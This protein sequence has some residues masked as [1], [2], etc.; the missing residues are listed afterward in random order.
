[1][2][3]ATEA[4]KEAAAAAAKAACRRLNDARVLGRAYDPS[5]VLALRTNCQARSQSQPTH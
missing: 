4:R 2:S 3:Y 1:M 5:D